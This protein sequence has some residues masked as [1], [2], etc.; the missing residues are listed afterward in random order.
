[1]PLGSRQ[2]DPLF[3]IVNSL[4]RRTEAKASA[5]RVLQQPSGRYERV[6]SMCE[7]CLY[8]T[9]RLRDIQRRLKHRRYDRISPDPKINRHTVY[10]SGFVKPHYP[11]PAI[12]IEVHIGYDEVWTCEQHDDGIR[13]DFGWQ[14]PRRFI[15]K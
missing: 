14:V 12:P 15:R 11:V 6:A 4:Q 10:A 7:T 13:G 3:D 9:D 2:S 8:V 5:R 1:M